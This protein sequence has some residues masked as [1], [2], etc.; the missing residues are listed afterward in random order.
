[1]RVQLETRAR[2][3][4]EG[5]L[6]VGWKVGINDPAMQKRLG[7]DGFVVGALDGARRFD[8]G[9][10]CRLAAPGRPFVEAEIAVRIDREI[11][12]PPS[13]A[14]AWA[15]AGA[16]AAAVEVVDYARP[17]DGLAAILT[18]SIFHSASVIGAPCPPS[19]F[20]R[21]AA[22]VPVL[23]KNSTRQGGP[24]DSLRIGDLGAVAA[25]VAAILIDGGERLRAGDWIL[26]GSWIT[27]VPVSAGDEV[28]VD[29][30][31]LGSVAVRFAA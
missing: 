11:A 3:S 15:A 13:A 19:A 4:A 27:P 21:L 18:H 29:F 23:T 5:V 7:L 8:S 14:E 10:T 20:G 2:R 16:L 12:T 30:G 1:M 17:T 9:A 24:Q 22:D 25:R 26:T 31:A 28:A 6:R